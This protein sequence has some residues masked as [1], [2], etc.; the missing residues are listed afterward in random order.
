MTRLAQLESALVKADAAGNVEDAKVLAAAIRS[1]R[2]GAGRAE[3]IAAATAEDQ[4]RIRSDFQN[5]TSPLENFVIGGARGFIDLIQGVKQL[6]LNAGAAVGLADDKT[7]QDYN[8]QVA[9][10]A[11][12]YERNMGHSTAA[13]IG[14]VGA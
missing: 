13:G 7:A 4:A 1:E 2:Q 8:A 12:L 10:E 9:D 3:R 14:R 11:A 6:G 5:S